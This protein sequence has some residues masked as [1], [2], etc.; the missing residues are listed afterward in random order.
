[1]T[2]GT[3]AD[4]KRICQKLASV[5]ADLKAIAILDNRLQLD[6]AQVPYSAKQRLWNARNRLLHGIALTAF[7][8]P[9]VLN[10]LILK[11]SKDW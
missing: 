3:R 4:Q 11:A 9:E 5:D 2:P 7:E 1:M 10:H 8:V 6:F